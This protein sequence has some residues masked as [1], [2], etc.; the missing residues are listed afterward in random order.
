MRTKTALTQ[1]ADLMLGEADALF[2]E[3]DYEGAL[4]S[5]TDVSARQ[6]RPHWSVACLALLWREA[7]GERS[8]VFAAA[9]A[10]GE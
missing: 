1:R 9:R 2:V 5:Y 4:T 10:I 8:A 7:A 3:E 6:T